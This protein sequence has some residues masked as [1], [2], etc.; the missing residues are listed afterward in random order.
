MTHTRLAEGHLADDSH[1]V[2]MPRVAAA[3]ALLSEEIARR[4]AAIPK[5]ETVEGRRARETAMDAALLDR[6]ARAT[7]RAP[8]AWTHVIDGF[9]AWLSRDHAKDGA[10]KI[11]HDHD[12][13]VKD[14]DDDRV[15]GD[16]D[17]DD[18]SDMSPISDD[19][20]G[21]T[22]HPNGAAAT[23]SNFLG[24]LA[25]MGVSI[26]AITTHPENAHLIGCCTHTPPLIEA[27][28]GYGD[29]RFVAVMERDYDC[30][31]GMLLID[32]IVHAP[33]RI[34]INDGCDLRCQNSSRAA[35]ALLFAFFASGQTSMAAFLHQVFAP[36]D[37]VI[38]VIHAAGWDTDG[39]RFSWSDVRSALD[40]QRVAC[41][42]RDGVVVHL[43]WYSGTLIASGYEY[44][45]YETAHAPASTYG[46][47]PGPEV[48]PQEDDDDGAGRRGRDDDNGK[49]DDER[50][51]LIDAGYISPWVV[52][53]RCRGG[54]RRY[55]VL[56]LYPTADDL[57]ERMDAIADQIAH[58]HGI[59]A[60]DMETRAHGHTRLNG[61]TC[62]AALD[63]VFDT[64]TRSWRLSARN[65]RLIGNER[66]I[67]PARG[68]YANWTMVCDMLPLGNRTNRTVHATGLPFVR[69]QGHLVGADERAASG[70]LQRAHVVVLLC[71]SAPPQAY[72]REDVRPADG[73]R[74]R[75][76]ALVQ[77]LGGDTRSAAQATPEAPLDP[78]CARYRRAYLD[79]PDGLTV[80]AVLRQASSAPGDAGPAAEFV[81]ALEWLMAEFEACAR[82]FAAD[83]ADMD[84]LP[85]PFIIHW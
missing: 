20:G 9:L 75:I 23:A 50:L 46:P 26:Y 28:C 67:D 60:G 34:G 14:N 56:L 63:K 57:V 36:F 24:P 21:Q 70:P 69:F 65:D 47:D 5:E 82:T 74:S 64:S 18:D 41:T 71:E 15:V 42:R 35:R 13:D 54:R 49:D 10:A 7:P 85:F 4:I 52:G 78:I 12:G 39:K 3:A 2:A 61:R 58:Q 80:L 6:C 16:G 84:P 22:D 45:Y 66:Y 8:S 53:V 33:T 30:T 73:E 32:R 55:P 72:C 27:D 59:D 1:A 40:E 79:S 62:Q 51:W 19:G 76:E 38:D 77:R 43:I 44:G 29:W 83:A 37:H 68:L 48:P 11:A 31:G 25:R 81:A 17:G